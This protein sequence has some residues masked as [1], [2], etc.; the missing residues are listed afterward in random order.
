M[1]YLEDNKLLSRY[2]YDYRRLRTTGL[3][4]TLFLDYV[5]KEVDKGNLMGV[6]FMDLSKAFDTIAHGTLLEKLTTYSINNNELKWFT[7]YLFNRSQQVVLDNVK[8]EV[9]QVHCSVPQGDKF[10]VIENVLNNKLTNVAQY[11]HDKDLVINLKK[12]KT[13]SMLIGTRES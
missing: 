4:V 5:R 11:L 13:E 3:A 9:E 12:G 7:S 2:Q 1:K 8:S 10:Y 6:V